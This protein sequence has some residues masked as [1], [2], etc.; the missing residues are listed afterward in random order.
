MQN[1]R[2]RQRNN[3]RSVEKQ[4]IQLLFLRLKDK[5]YFQQTDDAMAIIIEIEEKLKINQK[6]TDQ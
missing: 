4:Y 5:I 1:I 3:K 6:N 2:T